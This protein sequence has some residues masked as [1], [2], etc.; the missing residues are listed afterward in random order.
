[1]HDIMGGTSFDQKV[2]KEWGQELK[3]RISLR[4]LNDNSAER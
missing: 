3:K 2:D 1:M 4:V